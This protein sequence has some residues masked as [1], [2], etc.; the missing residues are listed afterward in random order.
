MFEPKAD[1]S[2]T[3]RGI[4]ENTKH[5]KHGIRTEVGN[6]NKTLFWYHNWIDTNPL[7]QHTTQQIPTQLQDHTVGEMWEGSSGW[8]WNLFADLLPDNILQKIASVEINPQESTK[9]QFVWDGASHGGFSTKTAINYIRGDAPTQADPMW[10]LIW[11][12]QVPHRIRFFLWLVG[13]ERLM[14]NSNRF[15]RGLIDNPKCRGCLD[16]DETTLHLL[17]DCKLASMIWKAVLPPSRNASFFS[18]PCR[19]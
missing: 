2:N 14:T 13:H 18:L 6:G 17:R 11:A 12:S 16:G 1:A 19:P 10:T 3:W 7:C 4:L 8:K 5:L 9:D 15:A